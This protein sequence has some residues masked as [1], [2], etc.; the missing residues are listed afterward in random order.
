MPKK[1]PPLVPSFLIGMTAA[2]GPTTIVCCFGCPLSSGP[3]APGSSVV[4][5]SV[6]GVGHR[7]A[8]LHEEDAEDQRDRQK[9]VDDDAPHIDEEVA[10]VASPRNARMIAV[11]AQKP[12]DAERNM[13]GRMKKIWLKFERCWS[14]E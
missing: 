9:D 14:P 6:D 11:S 1:P 13:F 4:A 5:T 10:D 7:H 12:T 3:I 2:T 8:L